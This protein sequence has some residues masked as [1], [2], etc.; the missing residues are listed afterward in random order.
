M[1]MMWVEHVTLECTAMHVADVFNR[2]LCKSFERRTYF[3]FGSISSSE[4]SVSLTQSLNNTSYGRLFG[5]VL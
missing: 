2:I 5:L 4:L 1:N 3:N